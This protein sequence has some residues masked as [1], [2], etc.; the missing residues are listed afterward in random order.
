MSKVTTKIMRY[1]VMQSDGNALCGDVVSDSVI[2]TY[3]DTDNIF[4]PNM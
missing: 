4:L 2:K 3:R 1:S